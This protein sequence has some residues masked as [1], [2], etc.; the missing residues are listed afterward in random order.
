[1]RT[2]SRNQESLLRI[3]NQIAGGDAGL[4][5]EAFD[6]AERAEGHPPDLAQI[7]IYILEKRGLDDL[8]DELRSSM[9]E[10]DKLTAGA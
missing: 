9:A 8:A 1:M 3:L 5:E 10:E 2:L 6:N 7:A 4:V